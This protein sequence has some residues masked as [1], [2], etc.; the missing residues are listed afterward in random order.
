MIKTGET[1]IRGEGKEEGQEEQIK[2]QKEQNKEEKR[3]DDK[4]GWR[5]RVLNHE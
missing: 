3:E 5:V 4:I 1:N 2:I